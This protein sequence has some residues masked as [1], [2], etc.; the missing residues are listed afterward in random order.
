MGVILVS[1]VSVVSLGIIY[2][3]IIFIP[4][5]AA[6]IEPLTPNLV[7]VSWLLSLTA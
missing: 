3:T 4:H 2:V 1:L 6:V 7:P 5:V